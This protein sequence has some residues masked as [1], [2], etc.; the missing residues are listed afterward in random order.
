MSTRWEPHGARLADP[1]EQL[2][3]VLEARRELLLRVHRHR[4]SREELEDCLGQTTVELLASIR[5]GLRFASS[6]HMARVLEQ[7]F[8]SR[9]HDRRRALSGRSPIQAALHDAVTIDDRDLAGV[10]PADPRARTEDLVVARS[11][12]ARM[13]EL[14]PGLSPD[15]R[16][17]IASQV[18]LGLGR[19]EFC[20]RSGWSVEKYRKVDQ[21][22]RARLRDLMGEPTSNRSSRAHVPHRGAGSDQEPGTDP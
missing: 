21:R 14:A 7:R 8:L 20:G 12:L 6:R 4:L 22:G 15:Q 5:R 9:I 11:E 16:L 18:A 19:G 2:G 13:L 3:L 1:G 17:V 10:D